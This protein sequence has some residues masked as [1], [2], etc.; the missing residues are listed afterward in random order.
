MIWSEYLLI[1][2]GAL[3][4]VA[5][6]LWLLLLFV[7]F[8]LMTWGRFTFTAST[9]AEAMGRAQYYRWR[10]EQMEKKQP[11]IVRVE[12]IIDSD[13]SDG[14]KVEEIEVL[15]S[16][17]QPQMFSSEVKCVSVSWDGDQ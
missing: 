14:E 2:L 9:L 10:C 5:L 11:F 12:T 15:L 8:I 4:A 16:D 13:M 6:G 7:H 1:G 17:G 3:V